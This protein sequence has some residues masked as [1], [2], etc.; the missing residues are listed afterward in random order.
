[1]LYLLISKRNAF[2]GMQAE[3]AEDV[4]TTLKRR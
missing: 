4:K 3:H 2:N 1:M